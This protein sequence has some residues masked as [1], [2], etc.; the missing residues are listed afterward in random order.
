MQIELKSI[1]VY[2]RMSEETT[3][4]SASLY[5]DGKK[6]GTAKNDGRGGMTDYYYNH[7]DYCDIIRE[8]E[9]YC[10]TLPPRVFPKSEFTDSFSVPMDLEQKIEELLYDYLAKRDLEKFEKKKIKRMETHI[11]WGDDA[12]YREVRWKD[13]TIAQVISKPE[14][15]MLIK[16]VLHKLKKDYP[17]GRL[18]NTNIP[19][20]I[21]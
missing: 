13:V 2:D 20:S 12:S 3:A 9:S 18:L 4:F 21:L 7:P 5:I 16:Q 15:P 19:K 1:R 10:K 6:V 17:D 11:L 8:A 14:G